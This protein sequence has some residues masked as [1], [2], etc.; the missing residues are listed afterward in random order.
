MLPDDWKKEIDEAVGKASSAAADAEKHRT[1]ENKEIAARVDELARQVGRY[2]AKEEREAPAKKFRENLTIAALFC[3]ALFTLALAGFT[4]WQAWETR[5]AFEPINRQATDTHTLANAANN[6]VIAMQGQLDAMN[7]EQRPYLWLT[8]DVFQPVIDKEG[9]LNWDA[10]F[11]NS[12]KTPANNVRL[13]QRKV[14]VFD[15]WRRDANFSEPVS[16]TI[17]PP[18]ISN[19]ITIE[20]PDALTPDQ[21]RTVLG[22]NIQIVAAI[23]IQYSGVPGTTYE[24]DACISHLDTGA[25]SFMSYADNPA[26]VCKNEMK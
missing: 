14:A 5:Q 20:Y 24:S 22:H 15:D 1:E 25:T 18:G 21:I 17:I 19:R 11:I 13:V 3:A 6:Q 16:G 8:N 23:V 12:G 9:R 2:N 7:R 10:K 26:V 4:A